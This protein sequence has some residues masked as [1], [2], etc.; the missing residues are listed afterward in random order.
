MKKQ[1]GRLH[2]ITDQSVQQRHSHARLAGL[3]VAGGA[4]IIQFRDKVMGTRELIDTARILTDICS[5]SG[6]PLIINDRVDIVLAVD[7]GGVHLGRDDLPIEAARKIL[8]PAKI[9]GG[10]AGSLEDAQ[11]AQDAGADYV[12]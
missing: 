11:S 4:G 3:A 5:G 2:V 8:G 7:A 9:I 1:I 6:I 10:S 12:G